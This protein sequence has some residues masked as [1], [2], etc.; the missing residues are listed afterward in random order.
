MSDIIKVQVIRDGLV[1]WE[2][3]TKSD[4]PKVEV[5]DTDGIDDF[6]KLRTSPANACIYCGSGEQ[7]SREH[8]LAY[9]MGGTTT[10]P[11]GSCE[12]CRQITHAFETAVLRGPMRMVRYIQNLPSGTKHR[13]IPGTI[14]VKIIVNDEVRTIDAPREEAPILLPFPV[15]EPPGYL[16]PGKTDLQ[17]KGVVTGSFGGDPNEFGK[18]H[19]ANSI[20]ITVG[21]FYATAFARMLA[22][23]AYAAA[24]AYGLLSRLKNREELVHAMMHEPNIIGRFVGTVPEP[25]RKYPGVHHRISNH[26]LPAHRILYSTVQIFASAGAPSYIVILGALKDDDPMDDAG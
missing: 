14:P 19:G 10:I 8:I 17:L 11:N 16:E 15:F 6:S 9:A 24:H 23:T 5:A 21:G 20:E 3:V 4:K 13:D 12:S 18:K 7:L 1:H 26:I 22:K 25:Y 2:T